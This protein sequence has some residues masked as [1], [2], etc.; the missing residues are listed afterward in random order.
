M[1]FAQMRWTRISIHRVVL[2]WLRAERN[3]NVARQLS[4]VPAL[5][6]SPGLAHLLDDPDFNSPDENRARLRLLYMIRSLF[7]V[8]I[9][10]DTA[11][12][13]VRN[14]TDDELG[15]LRAVN[16]GD[17]TDPTEQNRLDRIAARKQLSLQVQPQNWDP[18]IL[19]GHHRNGPFAILEGNNRLTAYAGSGRRDLDIPVF[20]GLSPMACIWHISDRCSSLMQDLVRRQ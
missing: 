6:W 14:L 15:E 19:W 18:P 16:Y 20:I 17:W 7:L 12:Y 13:E 9:P 1:S 5:V 2:A 3:T 4:A 8:E 11:W 10:P